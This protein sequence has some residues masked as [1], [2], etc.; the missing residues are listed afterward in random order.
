MTHSVIRNS[1]ATG[2]TLTSKALAKTRRCESGDLACNID[3]RT[4]LVGVEIIDT[5][6]EAQRPHEERNAT[7]Q[8]YRPFRV[9]E[10]HP[11]VCAPYGS[12]LQ[13]K[14]EPAISGPKGEVVPNPDEAKSPK[15]WPFIPSL[16][17]L[18]QRHGRRLECPRLRHA[19]SLVEAHAPSGRGRAS[20]YRI[21]ESRFHHRLR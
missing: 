7:G 21:V 10:R 1:S 16:V 5:L 13:G 20:L 18:R 4:A 9:Q 2:R 15:G 8:A 14:Q 6:F 19:K 17:L 3:Q 11:G 12:C